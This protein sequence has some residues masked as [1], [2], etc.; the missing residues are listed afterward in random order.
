M[1]KSDE[2]H[3]EALEAVRRGSYDVAL[4]LFELALEETPEDL[5]LLYNFATATLY[6]GHFEQAVRLF[7]TLL[8]LNPHHVSALTNLGAIRLTQK[9]WVAAEEILQTALAHNRHAVDAH[10]NLAH[11]YVATDRFELALDHYAQAISLSRAHPDAYN[12]QGNA[13]QALGLYREATVS[14]EK[15]LEINPEHHEARLNLGLMQ[16]RLRQWDEGWKNFEQ[17]LLRQESKRLFA[18]CC[19]PRWH[20]FNIGETVAVVCEEGYGDTIQFVR[21][22][23]RL[24][25]AGC[26]VVL[27]A[28]PQLAKLLTSSFPSV[29][30]RSVLSDTDDVTY[31]LPLMSLPFVLNLKDTTD[32]FRIPYLRES[33]HTK[34]YWMALL[35]PRTA[36]RVGLAWRGSPVHPNDRHRS[37][38]LGMLCEALVPGLQ[39][40]AIQPEFNESERTQLQAAGILAW[41]ED[42][43]DFSE[44][45]ALIGCLDLVISVDTSVAHLAGALG[46]PVWLLLPFVSDWRWALDCTDSNWYPSMLLYRQ[47]SRDDW[48]EVLCK[49]RADLCYLAS[50]K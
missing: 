11:V 39:Y 49:L 40:V 42:L 32:V 12:G 18:G 14:Y 8:E 7:E 2:L 27:I 33:E 26:K 22:I 6:A 28:P 15:A 34:R 31:H 37:L 16:L 13:L 17:R 44:T 3:D 41:A 45:A 19:K 30:V 5:R 23:H 38:P 21:F 4:T 50:V 25:D 29:T 1:K 43:K 9:S 36:L 10:Y 48:H 46:Q 20:P 47:N 35:G 24:L